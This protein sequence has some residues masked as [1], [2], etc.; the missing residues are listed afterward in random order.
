MEC[1]EFCTET[2]YLG[3]KIITFGSAK[4][5]NFWWGIPH[6]SS[7]EYDVD[8]SINAL[9]DWNYNKSKRQRRI[10]KCNF[11]SDPDTYLKK[12]RM[13]SHW[14]SPTTPLRSVAFR[15]EKKR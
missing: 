7:V 8:V 1:E 3:P 2:T 14:T 10:D 11:K 15:G 5:E 13:K 12:S 4:Y 9:R 6:F